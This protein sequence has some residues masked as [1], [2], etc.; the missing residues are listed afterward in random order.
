[1]A[2]M[3]LAELHCAKIAELRCAGALGHPAA[4]HLLKLAIG[5]TLCLDVLPAI[6][7]TEH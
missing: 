6:G 2:L 1:M 5:K 3:H 7:E 4:A